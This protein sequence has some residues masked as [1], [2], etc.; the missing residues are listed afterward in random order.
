MPRETEKK[1]QERAAMKVLVDLLNAEPRRRD[2]H[3][4]DDI[5]DFD[6]VTGDGKWIAVEVTTDTSGADAALNKELDRLNSSPLA[7]TTDTG[8][9]VTVRTPGEHPND[10]RTVRRIVQRLIEKLPELLVRVI[11][12]GLLD[13][14]HFW[15]SPHPEHNEHPLVAELRELS[16]GS[17]TEM[18]HY[19]AEDGQ[20][21]IVFGPHGEPF[22]GSGVLSGN[23]LVDVANKTLTK[24][25]SRIAKMV[26]TGADEVHL[27]VWVR[28]A[29]KHDSHSGGFL[30][31]ELEGMSNASAP[32]LEQADKV[33]V[34]MYGI[35]TDGRLVYDVW[36]YDR[37]EGWVRHPSSSISPI[38]EA[39]T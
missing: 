4:S 12:E 1:R 8:W 9:S 16:V 17:I 26:L 13:N 37:N 32:E 34:A 22:G 25:R 11:V 21:M 5:H 33:W 23:D 35:A 24:K 18:P 29:Q 7:V 39:G 10:V 3:G 36:S 30:T 19:R 14:L 20:P 27:F 38:E 2:V 31:A 15:V 28:V 6:L